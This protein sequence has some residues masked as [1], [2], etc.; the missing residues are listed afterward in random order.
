MIKGKAKYQQPE[1]PLNKDK[2]NNSLLYICQKLGGSCD[3]YSLLKILYFAECDHLLKYGR[4]ITGDRI[5][6]MEHGPVPSFSYDQVKFKHFD[7]TLFNRSEDDVIS[8][9]VPPQLQYLSESDIESLDISISENSKLGFG[10][11]KKKS[12]NAA[13]ESAIEQK[14]IASTISAIEIAKSF[15]AKEGMIKYISQK[16]QYNNQL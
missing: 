5:V 10:Q 16:I 3:M 15:G 13:Y 4:P 7:K 12:H 11:L 2:A 6:A 1:F 9:K 8:A 14:G